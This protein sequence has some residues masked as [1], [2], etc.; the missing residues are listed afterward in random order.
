[1]NE[2]DIK[3]L[4]RFLDHVADGATII[5]HSTREGQA[6]EVILSC[7]SGRLAVE[8][9][10]LAHAASAGLIRRTRLKIE[11]TAE[12]AHFITRQRAEKTNAFADQHRD[13]EF[14]SIL[15]EGVEQT[16]CINHAESPLASLERLKTK[17]GA[18]YFPVEAVAAGERLHA[19]FT[20]GHL[21]PRVTMSFEPRLSGT[22]KGG[23][24]GVSEISDSALAARLKVTR[25]VE[26]MGPELSGVALDVC[27]FMKGLEVVERERQWPVR[28]AKL[29]L[30]TAL[31]SLHRHYTPVSCAKN[32]HWG[33]EGY[34]PEIAL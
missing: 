2:R 30:K 24:G 1:M 3:R 25:A 15:V 23:R 5:G 8:A 17:E 4:L 33:E 18:P 7:R 20:R 19:D 12:A 21:Q 14:S 28:S 16:V 27:C 6:D 29:M 11:A 31:L 34:R 32:R 10:M 9:S 26:A 22:V 13:L